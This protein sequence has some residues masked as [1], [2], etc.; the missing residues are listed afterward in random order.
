MFINCPSYS[1]SSSSS[2]SSSSSL[3]LLL[4]LHLLLL[5][6]LLQDP[7]EEAKLNNC[8]THTLQTLQEDRVLMKHSALVY[9]IYVNP[10]SSCVADV[11]TTLHTLS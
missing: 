7:V 2:S 8:S 11:R 4:L 1:P 5:R 3:L 10:F 9:N 6:L